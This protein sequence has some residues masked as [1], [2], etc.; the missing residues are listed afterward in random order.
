MGTTSAVSSTSGDCDLGVPL[1]VERGEEFFEEFRELLF[2]EWDDG[3]EWEETLDFREE[4][5]LIDFRLLELLKAED[6]LE[7]TEWCEDATEEAR[8]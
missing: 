4:L 5:L 2:D 1:G 8:I 7:F 6:A 3:E